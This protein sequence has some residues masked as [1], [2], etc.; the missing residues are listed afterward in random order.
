VKRGY[1][2]RIFFIDL[3][4]AY[5]ADGVSSSARESLYGAVELWVPACRVARV[6]RDFDRRRDADPFEAL[7]VHQHVLD[8]KQEQAV[9]TD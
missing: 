8:R 9:V 1:V 6:E 5:A 7:T 2:R 3:K 4:S